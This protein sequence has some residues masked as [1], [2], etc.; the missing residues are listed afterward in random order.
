MSRHF[1][2]T[3]DTSPP[4][5]QAERRVLRDI[6][7]GGGTDTVNTTQTSSSAPWAGVD[8]YLRDIFSQS[9]NM[10]QRGPYTGQYLTSQ[11][12]YSAQA[13][14][15]QAQGALDPNSLTSQAQNEL[16]KTISGQYLNIDSNPAAQAAINAAT[17]NVNSQFSGDNYG[18]SAN[19]EWLARASTEAAT[20]FLMQERQNQLN[21]LQMAPYLQQANTGQLAA[22]GAAQEARG[23]AE[24][25]AQQQEYA[26]PWLNLFNYQRGIAGANQGAG[27][28]AVTTQG[29]QPYFKG[30]PLANALGM[31]IGALSLYNMGSGLWGGGAAAGGGAASG[32]GY[33]YG[34]TGDFGGGYG[35]WGYYG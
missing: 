23:Q 9:Q 5:E 35:D 26:A 21:A 1:W 25:G 31:G 32:G 8:P 10:Y 2:K 30:N 33:D 11:S 29:Q 17:R 28:G 16:G 14:Q 15:M 6:F 27:G 18:S 19:R 3:A 4:L 12:P 20:P 24:I 22:A 7:G 13:I 34:M